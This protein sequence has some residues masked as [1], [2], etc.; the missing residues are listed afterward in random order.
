MQS[1]TMGIGRSTM[2]LSGK[3][4]FFRNA[5]SAQTECD[6]RYFRAPP[7]VVEIILEL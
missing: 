6:L 2:L 5:P 7:S 4:N 3:M 1:F